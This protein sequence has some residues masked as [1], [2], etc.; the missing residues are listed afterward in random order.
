MDNSDELLF[1]SDLHLDAQETETSKRLLHFLKARG[2]NARALYILGDL[3]EVWLG[4]DDPADGLEPVIKALQDYSSRHDLY[5]CHGN[6]DFLIGNDFASCIGA[7]LIDDPTIIELNGHKAALMHGD[8][9][10]TDDV[11]YQNFRKMVRT[12]E[13]RHQFTS[14]PLQERQNIAHDLRARSAEAMSN[15]KED[16]M[17]VN[18]Q[19]VKDT[20]AN[21]G[22][23]TLIHGHTH[24]PGIHT[25][26]DRLERFVLGD[27]R[28]GPSFLSWKQGHFELIDHRL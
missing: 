8:L 12:P 17:D 7:T 25:Y 21:L 1:V 15:K 3:F 10:C 20:F 13:W 18:A 28:P 16:I 23:D 14:K 26:D 9:L 4:D 27:W 11:D 2:D 22:V 19:T 24:R 6:R 5:L